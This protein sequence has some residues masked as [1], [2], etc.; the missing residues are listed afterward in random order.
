MSSLGAI[1]RE[2]VDAWRGL[3]RTYE[4]S[5]PPLRVSPEDVRGYAETVATRAREAEPLRALILGVTPD[6][7]RLPWPAGTD[8]VAVDRS[9]AML[10]LV[11]PG[12][13]DAARHGEWTALPLPATSRDVALCDGGLHLLDHP[14]G[15][16]AFA[17][18]LARVVVPG[19]LVAM[20]LFVP[21]PR[22]E[23]A[24]EVLRDLREGRVRDVNVLKLRLGMAM[25]DD[26]SLGVRVAD[27]WR[28]FHAAEPDADRLLARCGWT[29]DQL[30]TLEAY[31][32]SPAVYSFVGA[33][34]AARLFVEETGAFRLESLR[35]P[36]YPLGERCPSVVLRRTAEPT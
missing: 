2:T 4:H 9:P 16:R 6:L 7:C 33:E 22:R 17:R 5:G 25:Q 14:A 28:A 24:G 15:Q 19:G 21:P 27:V 31:R 35:T 23:S 34:Q 26:A 10:A 3:A 20:R 13:R 8:L 32:E 36:T 11:W 1:P 30:A 18:E 29:R 12:P